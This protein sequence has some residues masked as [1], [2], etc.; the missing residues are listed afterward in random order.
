MIETQIKTIN[1]ISDSFFDGEF[2]KKLNKSELL[3]FSFTSDTKELKKLRQLNIMETNHKI[4]IP[5]VLL[6][7]GRFEVVIFSVIFFFHYISVKG[8]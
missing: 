7:S 4:N 1:M 6:F 8:L 2:S 3:L 5:V